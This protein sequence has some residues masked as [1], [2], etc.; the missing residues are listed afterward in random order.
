MFGIQVN[1]ASALK[2]K[3]FYTMQ[4]QKKNEKTKL[5]SE[6]DSNMLVNPNIQIG[7]AYLIFGEFIK[8]NGTINR[9]MI[10]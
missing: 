2:Y 8:T 6:R 5:S 4:F 1:W 10:K 3:R 7:I 9:Q